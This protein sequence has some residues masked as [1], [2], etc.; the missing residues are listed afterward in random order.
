MEFKRFDNYAKIALKECLEGTN[1]VGSDYAYHSFLVWFEDLEYAYENSVLYLRATTNDGE[2]YYWPPLIKNDV[3]ITRLQA[4]EKLPHNA[5][6]AFSTE[7]FANEVGDKFVVSNDRDWAEYIYDAKEFIAMS[8]KKYH[9]KRNH[10]AKF[11]SEYDYSIDSIKERDLFDL[12]K[13][14]EKWLERQTFDDDYLRGSAR[15]ENEI[16]KTWYKSALDG[17]ILCDVLRVDNKVVGVT[18]GE[19]MP[20]GNAVVMYEKADVNFEGAYTFLAHEFA[21]RHFRNC[22][23]INRQEDMGL[24]GL[25]K[26]KLSYCPAFLLDK[27]VLSPVALNKLPKSQTYPRQDANFDSDNI[28]IRLLKPENYDELMTFYEKGISELYDKKWYLNYTENELKQ[29]LLKGYSFGAFYDGRL[30][31]TCA[32]DSDKEYG[33]TLKD[34]CGDTSDKQYF[35]FSGIM[36]DKDFRHLHASRELCNYVINFARDMYEN[37]VLCAVVQ[38]DNLPSLNNLKKL[39]FEVV[40]EKR[41][42]EYDFKYLTLHL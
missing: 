31:S 27:F 23:Y 21:S 5:K 18:I 9:A 7:D 24:E 32:V 36:T 25:R 35:E 6:F 17:E 39:G 40:A 28:K 16:L 34:I 14:E 12:E 8:G 3:E 19:I 41:H 10:I 13:F 1:F 26:S 20:S 2:L 38:H 22:E 11:K 37:A 30:I 4:I 42:D 33:D 29:L 15:R